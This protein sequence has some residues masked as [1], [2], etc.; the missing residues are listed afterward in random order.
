MR[1]LAEM[2]KFKPI[3]ARI[4][5]GIQVLLL[6]ESLDHLKDT[7]YFEVMLGIFLGN[8]QYL[9]IIIFRPCRP[10]VRTFH[11]YFL[12]QIMSVFIELSL[13]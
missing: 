2:L 5:V 3:Q 7:R 1:E 11:L 12:I 13:N 4:V 6:K 8:L 9:Y 10:K